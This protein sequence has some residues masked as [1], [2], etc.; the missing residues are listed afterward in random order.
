MVSM[1]TH[2]NRVITKNFVGN[3]ASAGHESYKS[4]NHRGHEGTQRKALEG[5][6]QLTNR[7]C[8][9][10]CPAASG[11]GAYSPPASFLPTPAANPAAVYSACQESAR[12]PRQTSR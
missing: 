1:G 9:S 5:V 6:L 8:P 12:E 7:R 10:L 2:Q 4:L 3:P 11:A